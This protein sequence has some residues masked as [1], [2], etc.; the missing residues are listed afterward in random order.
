MTM[1]ILIMMMIIKIILIIIIRYDAKSN[2]KKR[3]N[4][5]IFFFHLSYDNY[6]LSIEMLLTAPCHLNNYNSNNI[7]TE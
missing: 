7:I 4:R 3:A 2:M 1:I 5:S 6:A